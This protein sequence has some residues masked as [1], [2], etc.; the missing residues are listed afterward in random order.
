VPRPGKGGDW[1]RPLAKVG[2]AGMGREAGRTEKGNLGMTRSGT[3]LRGPGVFQ[4]ELDYQET[5]GRQ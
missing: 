2:K 3:P 4:V 5:V 1:S